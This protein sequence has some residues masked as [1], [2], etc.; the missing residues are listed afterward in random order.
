MSESHAPGAST[1]LLALLRA[2]RADATKRWRRLG[3]DDTGPYAFRELR[4]RLIATTMVAT[5][6][7]LLIVSV[8]I[9]FVETSL[10]LAQIDRQL[11]REANSK[12]A[13]GLPAT[14]T[15]P[16]PTE[17]PY[18]P[19]SSN[20]FSIVVAP[21]GIIAEDD[22]QAQNYSLPDWNVVGVVITGAQATNVITATHGGYEFRL[23]TTPIKEN[24]VIVGVVQSGLSLDA[25]HQQQ[26]DLRFVLIVLDSFIALVT[27]ASSV[28]LTDR[29]LKPARVAFE[30]QRQ[31][32][33]GASHEL[34]TPLA[35]IR[36]LAELL[37]D[38][39][40][41]PTI[42]APPSPNASGVTE[43]AESIASDAE[44]II[45]EVDY[46]TRL[47]TDL[48]LLARD[49]HDRRA[50]N[51]VM[52]DVR[53]VLQGVI[54]KVEPLA[55]MRD[56]TLTSDLID[57]DEI[58]ANRGG[59][60]LVEGDPDRLRELALILLENAVRYTPRG[61]AVMVT[62]DVTRSAV[63]RGERRG[64]VT[65]SV[66]D[67]GVGIAPEDQPHVFEPFYRATS[68]TLRRA[69][70]TETKGESSAGSGLGL[71][72]AHWI[73]EAHHG[74]ISLSS[75]PGV[76]TTFTVELPLLT[77]ARATYPPAIAP[78]ASHPS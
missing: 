18:D 3:G 29:A 53:R 23:Y 49:E 12:V 21:G 36:S 6:L 55:A 44:E 60:A 4:R 77:Q 28:Y 8:A 7:V 24:S 1:R 76:G 38:H 27:L 46:M 16:D 37:A 15:P 78:H 67:T 2:L 25:Y 72:L 62:L 59:P 63:M 74:K 19:Q 54:V 51:W 31:F 64:H 39:R 42:E 14:I 43:G 40:C 13:E 34:R 66:R 58:K 35:V 61:G 47:V 57:K 9:Y 68:S 45:H 71:A 52:V 32:A 69:T 26:A 56:I 11:M 50:L 70:A 65:F 48:L 20:Y 17:R 5:T 22:D 75:Q 10:E 41:P 73:V 33:A 30:R